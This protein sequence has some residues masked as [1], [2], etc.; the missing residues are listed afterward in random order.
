M[1]SICTVCVYSISLLMCMMSCSLVFI[2]NDN[3]PVCSVFALFAQYKWQAPARTIQEESSC[4]SV[5]RSGLN[6][7]IK[8]F[9]FNCFASPATVWVKN[10]A[11]QKTAFFCFPSLIK[12]SC[13]YYTQLGQLIS[14]SLSKKPLT[15]Y[16]L[17]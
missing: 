5:H 13:W 17:G 2:I 16:S 9:P 8:Q 14:K 4:D 3:H 6:S 10:L 15:S 11:K 12:V 1:S 7:Y